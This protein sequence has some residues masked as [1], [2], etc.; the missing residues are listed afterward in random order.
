VA[1]NSQLCFQLLLLLSANAA[2]SPSSVLCTAP[3]LIAWLLQG[4]KIRELPK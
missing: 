3:V 1:V 4:N 2:R